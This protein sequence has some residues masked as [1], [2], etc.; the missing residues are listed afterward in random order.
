MELSK[1]GEILQKAAAEKSAGENAPGAESAEKT[2]PARDA[3]VK[4]E[5]ENK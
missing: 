2:E 1:I 4:E 5:G 3:E